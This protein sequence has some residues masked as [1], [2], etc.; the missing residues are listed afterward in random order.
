MLAAIRL[1]RFSSLR[2]RWLIMP[3]ACLAL[4]LM[5]LSHFHAVAAFAA[6]L[7]IF[8]HAAD[9]FAIDAYF[10]AI[11]PCRRHAADVFFILLTR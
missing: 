7:L 4:M 2:L 11:S 8:R 3:D 9:A 5:A 10:A 1:R 6:T